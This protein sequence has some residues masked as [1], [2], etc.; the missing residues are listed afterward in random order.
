LLRISCV[1]VVFYYLSCSAVM[2]LGSS[3]WSFEIRALS[4]QKKNG[5]NILVLVDTQM[6]GLLLDSFWR[7]P[8]FIRHKFIWF[9]LWLMLVKQEKSKARDRVMNNCC[10]CCCWCT[11]QSWGHVKCSNFCYKMRNT[12]YRQCRESFWKA[13]GIC[14][15]WNWVPYFY[16]TVCW[17]IKVIGI[18]PLGF[19]VYL[20]M[21]FQW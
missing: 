4:G 20:C 7:I 11:E 9:L 1:V 14:N 17:Y 19:G 6:L 16:L 18:S 10:C 13:T 5:Y 12:G 15:I 8:S 3:V 2:A 21:F